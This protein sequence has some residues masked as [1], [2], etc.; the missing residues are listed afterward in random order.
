LTKTITGIKSLGSY[1]A[2]AGCTNQLSIPSSL[3]NVNFTAGD[4]G[5]RVAKASLNFSSELT[6]PQ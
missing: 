4:N 6:G 3:S 1:V 5:G 2:F